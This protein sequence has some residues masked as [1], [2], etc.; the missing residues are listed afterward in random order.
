MSRYAGLDI[1]MRRSISGFAGRYALRREKVWSPYAA[2]EIRLRA[3]D[4]FRHGACGG[5]AA[6]PS[7]EGKAC[8]ERCAGIEIRLRRADRSG[9]R[10]LRGVRRFVFG[11]KQRRECRGDYKNA[12]KIPAQKFC[13]GTGRRGRR[14]LRSGT[15]CGGW[16]RLR[17]FRIAAQKFHRFPD[18]KSC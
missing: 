5:S 7:P 4:L 14:P 2:I 17:R 18:E 3:G 15:R 6:T 9:D 13:G 1:R 11:R 16:I 12:R 8:I 10:S